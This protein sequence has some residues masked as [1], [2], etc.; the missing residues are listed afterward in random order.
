MVTAV[1]KDSIPL[2]L[3]FGMFSV[4]LLFNMNRMIKVSLLF[5][6]YR[7]YLYIIK[8]ILE[9]LCFYFSFYSVSIN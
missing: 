4:C 8:L 9:L 2:L 1:D 5:K 6:V 7:S 3:I